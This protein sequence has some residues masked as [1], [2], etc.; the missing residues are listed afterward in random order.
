MLVITESTVRKPLRMGGGR[1]GEG[2][3]EGGEKEWGG[4]GVKALDSIG[5]AH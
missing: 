1:M 5:T 2:W 3:G 4:G